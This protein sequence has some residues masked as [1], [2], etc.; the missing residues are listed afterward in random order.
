LDD[1]HLGLRD[2]NRDE[3]EEHFDVLVQVEVGFSG[4]PHPIIEEG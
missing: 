1:P 4:E 2:G 3:L